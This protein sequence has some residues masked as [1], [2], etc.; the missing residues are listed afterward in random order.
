MAAKKLRTIKLSDEVWD[1]LANYAKAEG[2]DRTKLIERWAVALI[3]REH[4]HDPKQLAGQ[5]DM[6]DVLSIDGK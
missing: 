2:V 6:F 4:W 3:P 5:M 1:A